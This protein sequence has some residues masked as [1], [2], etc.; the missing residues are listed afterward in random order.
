MKNLRQSVMS[1]NTM[2]TVYPFNGALYTFYESP[3]LHRLDRNLNTVRKESLTKLRMLSH[4]SHSHYDNDGDMITLG[5]RMGVTGP[6]YTVTQFRKQ[7]DNKAK[8]TSKCKTLA[9]IR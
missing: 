7:E 1:D 5:L 3:Y 4:A 8:L 2:I 6:Q 9:N